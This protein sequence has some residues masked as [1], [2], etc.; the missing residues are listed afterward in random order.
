MKNKPNFLV[1]YVSNEPGMSLILGALLYWVMSTSAHY[2]YFGYSA[3]EAI[4]N[5]LAFSVVSAIC[6][7]ILTCIVLG[8]WA[9]IEN[10][11]WR[12]QQWKKIGKEED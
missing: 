2:F 3:G 1:Y 9:G 12:H 4:L 7:A 5:G 8:T 11:L 10:I 6:I